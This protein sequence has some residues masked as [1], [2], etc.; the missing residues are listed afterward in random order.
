MS[1]ILKTALSTGSTWPGRNSWSINMLDLLKS[2]CHTDKG[3][4][5]V[6]VL[7]TPLGGCYDDTAGTMGQTNAAL[8]LIAMLSTRSSGDKK[9]YS[10]IAFQRLAISWI[11][12][13]S[14]AL[15]LKKK[16]RKRSIQEIPV[17]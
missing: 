7:R 6:C 1:L 5:P 12:F 2:L 11:H 13:H 15:I 3:D 8:D 10:T 4:L 16:Q 17:S 9:L 14:V